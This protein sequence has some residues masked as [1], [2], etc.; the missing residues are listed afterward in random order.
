ML[1]KIW[2]E[3]L[4]ISR[5]DFLCSESSFLLLLFPDK[6]YTTAYSYSTSVL[7]D[8][9]N[10]L[11]ITKLNY[12]ILL[13]IVFLL[14]IVSIFALAILIKQRKGN[15]GFEKNVFP[16]KDT[17]SV[18]ERRV[19]VMPVVVKDQHS[20]K[21]YFEADVFYE[22]LIKAAT[23][24]IAFYDKEGN[25]RYANTA[26]YSL[27]GHNKLNSSQETND[28]RLHT[29][30]A[31]YEYNRRTALLNLGFYETE[32]RLQ[33]VE[34]YFVNVSSRSVSVRNEAGQI[35]GSLTIYRDISKL[36]KVNEDLVKANADAESSNRL[37]TSFLANIS[38]EIRTPLNSVI[39]FSNLLHSDN[40]TRE[41][42]EE[43]IEQINFNS[44]K[45]LQ[46]I[47][48]II[49]LSRLESSQIQ[50]TYEETSLHSVV[51]EIIDEVRLA[52]KRSAKPVSLNLKNDFDESAD[53]VF[54]DRIWLKRVLTHLMD[55]AVKFTLDGSIE[56][57]YHRENED[58]VFLIKDTGIGIN[59]EN[60]NKIFEGFNQEI[61]GHHR[62]FEGLGI[63]LTLAKEVVERMGGKI[64]VKSEKGIGSEFSFSIPYRPAN[65]PKPILKKTESRVLPGLTNWSTRKCLLVD[66][67]KDVLIYL[68]RI[69]LDTGMKVL[70][71]RSG[72]EA[73]SIIKT[74]SDIDI[75]LLDMQMPEMNGI[76]TAREIKKIRKDLPIIAQTAFVFEDDKDIVLEAGCDACLIK[77][78]RKDNLL[79]V[80]AS[81]VK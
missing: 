42:R 35:V 54:A 29:D 10:Y 43:Y 13:A 46:I 66:D 58:I 63:G 26:Y 14:L 55:N 51:G 3:G 78:I 33:H 6:S 48:D 74:V 31:D 72:F 19:E 52:L 49:D 9:D 24:G 8:T 59:K 81:F 34:G 64:F 44:E 75:V 60:L 47:G 7:T 16:M 38:H 65:S 41:T 21:E 50:I 22:M 37:K 68:N 80:M 1:L 61:S 25:M 39:G 15:K 71:S 17:I 23:D 40:I 62:P 79:S 32:I 70:T 12:Y 36:K 2:N 30:D 76:E 18:S 45:L 28:D 73:I 27:T 57:S 67:N 77:P 4:K 69:L 56:F 11:F 53:L 5:K 20:V